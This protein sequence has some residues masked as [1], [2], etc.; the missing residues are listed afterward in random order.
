MSKLYLKQI[1]LHLTVIF[2]CILNRD[3]SKIE[4]K[5]KTTKDSN[6]RTFSFAEILLKPF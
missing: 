3:K 2:K 6:Q 1:Q 4:K 5:K